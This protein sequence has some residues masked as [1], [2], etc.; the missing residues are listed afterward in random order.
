MKRST[1]C[2][3]YNMATFGEDYIQLGSKLFNE[4]NI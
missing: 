1:D 4:N 3:K 2:I